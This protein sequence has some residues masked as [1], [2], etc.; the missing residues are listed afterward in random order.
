MPTHT[1]IIDVINPPHSHFVAAAQG[2]TLSY[3]ANAINPIT[4]YVDYSDTGTYR[5]SSSSLPATVGP[6]SATT[7]AVTAT[8]QN[9]GNGLPH[10]NIQPVIACNYIIYIP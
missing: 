6:T 10:S 2:G 4:S 5:F 8:A 9:T 1:H 3:P 7:T